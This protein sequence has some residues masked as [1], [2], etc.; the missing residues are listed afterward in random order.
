LTR[1]GR[2]RLLGAVGVVVSLALVATMRLVA[3]PTAVSDRPPPSRPSPITGTVTGA[4]GQTIDGIQ[5]QANEA[6]AYHLHAHLT[7]LIDG[8]T[9]PLAD[10]I[11]IPIDGAGQARCYYWLHT[12]VGSTGLIHLESPTPRLYTLGQFFDVWG[13]RLGTHDLMGDTAGAVR[14][15]VDLQPYSGSPRDIPLS[16]HRQIVLEIG[17]QVTPPYYVFPPNY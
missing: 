11:G 14:A 4:T 7:I 8:H 9:V 17:R 16:G 1:G 10:L 15:Y 5:C 2:L 13:Q 3:P 6:L 12:H